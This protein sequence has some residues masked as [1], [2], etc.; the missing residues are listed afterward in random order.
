[1]ATAKMPSQIA[2]IDIM[3]AMK[4]EEARKKAEL[5]AL[6]QKQGAGS[7]L[8]NTDP[9]NIQGGYVV[10]KE[11]PLDYS[12]I[13]T[14]TTDTDPFGFIVSDPLKRSSQ[15]YK[16]GG[17]LK[18]CSCGCKTLLKKGKGGKVMESRNCK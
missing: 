14:H 11:K 18:K 17:S 4:A 8:F 6:M 15:M 1:M 16:T 5:E 12:K 7:N 9:H 13:G 10:P 3:G 2:N